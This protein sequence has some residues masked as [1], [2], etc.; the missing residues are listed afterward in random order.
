M[1]L[2]KVLVGHIGVD[3]GQVMICDPCYIDSSWKQEAFK[4]IRRYRHHGTGDV[5]EYGKNFYD[6]EK[7]IKGYDRT[8]NEMIAAKEVH[9]VP[10][11][12]AIHPF[13]YNA[14]CQATLSEDGFGELQD[15][16]AVVTSSGYG[17]GLYPVY[18]EM[19]HGRVKRVTIEFFSDEDANED[20]E[21]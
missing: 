13:S 5:L 16:T 4:N 9:E 10:T 19:E 6:Y 11:T 20:E 3:S 8:M 2:K 14:C 12:P 15:G 17:D 7:K 18:A 1:R 21:Y